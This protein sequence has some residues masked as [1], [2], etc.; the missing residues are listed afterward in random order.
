M[1]TAQKIAATALILALL[2][3]A[4]GIFSLGRSAMVSATKK[5]SDAALVD[6]TPFKTAQQLAQLADTP[7]EQELAKETLRISDYE[8]D[9]SFAL[10]LQDAEAHPPALSAE[11]KLIQQRLQKNQRLQQALEAQVDQLTAQVAKAT[12]ARKSDLQDQLDIAEASLDVADNDVDDANR[13]LADAGGNQRDRIAKMKQAHEDADKSRKKP[14]DIFPQPVPDKP[15]LIHHFQVWSAL[16]YKKR[17][18]QRARSEA[19]ALAASL[20]SRH[21]ALATQ[22][23]SEKQKSPDLAAHSRLASADSASD[24]GTTDSLI[25]SITSNIA[26]SRSADEKSAA[27]ATTKAITLDQKNLA[28]LDKRVDNEKELSQDYSLWMAIVA[29]R[30]RAVIRNILIAVSIVLVIALF[31]LFFNSWL[32]KVLGKIKVDRRQLQTLRTTASVTV[33][34]IAVLFVLLVIFGPPG[35]LGTFIGL[36]TAGLTVAL[37]DFIVGFLGWFVL[38]GKNGIRLGDW[39]KINGVTGEVVEIGLFHTVLLETG[40]WTDSGHPT[41]RRVTFTNSYAIEGHYF[42]FST[43]GQ[44][45]WDELQVVLPTGDDPYPMI[46]AIRKKVEEETRESG[47]QAEKE[48]QNAAYS[49]DMSTLSAAPAVNVKPVVGGVEVTVRYITQANQ[50]SLLRN[51]LN[52]AAVELLGKRGVTPVSTRPAA[53]PQT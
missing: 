51:K 29:A 11:A 31:G 44:W 13:D 46:E 27:L 1:R 26:K 48:W 15:G 19:D 36:A 28:G 53:E 17:L 49:R 8:L 4:Y 40:N 23:D 5:T 37:K 52:Q 42:N 16:N 45:L 34:V 22:I 47:Q 41:G 25:A 39:V 32:D 3:A 33:Q 20:T 50:R 6:Q 12:G 18:L 2:A 30:Q 10:A 14:D 9:Q 43:S 35:N 7:E 24:P 38:M 21:N